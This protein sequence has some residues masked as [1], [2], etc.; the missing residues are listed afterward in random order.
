MPCL[1]L[2]AVEDIMAPL[3]GLSIREYPPIGPD[4]LPLAN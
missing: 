1:G 2:L 3:K 4:G